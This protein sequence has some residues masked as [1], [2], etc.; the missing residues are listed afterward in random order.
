[1]P[2]TLLQLLQESQREFAEWEQKTIVAKSQGLFFKSLYQ[3]DTTKADA[4]T[5]KQVFPL[6]S[7][8]G[9]TLWV[10]QY[11]TTVVCEFISA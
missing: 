5:S 3:P 11:I 6:A 7:C 8:D 2:S 10:Y 9:S 4:P 1:L